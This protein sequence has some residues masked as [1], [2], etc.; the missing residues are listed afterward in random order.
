MGVDRK[1][2]RSI[3]GFPASFARACSTS[4]R[5]IM[6]RNKAAVGGEY[7][8]NLKRCPRK[9]LPEPPSVCRCAVNVAHSMRYCALL[10]YTQP[11]RAGCRPPQAARPSNATADVCLRTPDEHAPK[12][13]A[14]DAARAALYTAPF[15]VCVRFIYFPIVLRV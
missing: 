13:I 2:S 9:S 1:I 8:V 15:A 5:Q 12:S 4:R 6:S 7:Q 11:L 10:S 14:A 3:T